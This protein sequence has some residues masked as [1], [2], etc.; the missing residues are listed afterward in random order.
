M[1]QLLGDHD[2]VLGRLIEFRSDRVAELVGGERVAKGGRILANHF[3]DGIGQFGNSVCLG[4]SG[5]LFIV[6]PGNGVIDFSQ[7]PVQVFELF[8]ACYGNGNS[9]RTMNLIYLNLE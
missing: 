1:P 2:L 6:T 5:K 3:F 7:L 8:L 4:W 9:L